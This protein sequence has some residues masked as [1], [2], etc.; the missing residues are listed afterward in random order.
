MRYQWLVWPLFAALMGFALGGSVTWGI[1]YE[2]QQHHVADTDRQGDNHAKEKENR[3]SFWEKA[4]E[5]PVA[6]FTLWLAVATFGLWIVTWR[7]SLSQ[8]RDMRESIAIAAKTAEAAHDANRPWVEAIITEKRE[9]SIRPGRARVSFMVSLRNKGNSPATAVKARAVLVARP[10]DEPSS[11]NGA[12]AKLAQLMDYR[13]S[14][15]PDR[16]ISIFPGIE[17]EPQTYGSNIF[18][19]SLEEAVGGPGR[20]ARFWVAVGVRYKFGERT[21][22]TLY[23][24]ML[25]FRGRPQTIA[26]SENIGFGPDEF[27]LAGM[28]LQYAT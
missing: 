28:D 6:N 18:R 27:E 17:N 14:Q 9:F 26:V 20:E 8:A 7:A 10:A 25:T 1:M 11:E 12:L 22:E 4:I 21:G 24:Y 15:Q 19:E 3:N 16:G 2:P 5:D 13:E 23:A